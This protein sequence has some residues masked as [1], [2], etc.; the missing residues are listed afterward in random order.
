MKLQ[1]NLAD[2]YN[3]LA[4]FFAEIFKT[5][6][7]ILPEGAFYS[8]ALSGGSTP[9]HIFD[10]LAKY[11]KEMVDWSKIRFF[12]GDE[13][14]VPPDHEESNYKMTKEHLLDHIPVPAENIF[15]IQGE[16]DPEKEARR[17]SELVSSL[18]PHENN[19]PVF[20]LVMLG[21]GDD[22]HTASIFPPDIAL[23]DHEEL[24][25]AT[26]NPYSG[27]NRISATG[28]VINYARRTIF[29]ATGEAKAAVIAKIIGKKEGSELYPASKV[30]PLNGTCEYA[31]DH[32]AASLLPQK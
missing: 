12:W 16:N 10:N 27:Q 2:D 19:R 21:I 17:Y 15:R 30:E 1:V 11:S 3:G 29:V 7:S 28:Q 4:N 14:C 25:I 31:L 22:G 9:L 23:F 20:D 6:T 8:V 32:A 18:L 13:R 5:Q 26:K 24:F